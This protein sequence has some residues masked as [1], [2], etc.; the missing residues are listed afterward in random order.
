M[1]PSLTID[2]RGILLHVTTDA[3]E[4]VAV[5]LEP[6][7]V[8]ELASGLERARAQLKTGAGWSKLLRAVG[9]TL[10]DLSEKPDGKP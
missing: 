2:E 6:Q 3:G 7:T 8:V 10:L 9:R 5:P 1:R 4:G